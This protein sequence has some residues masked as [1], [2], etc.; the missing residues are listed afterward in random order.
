[1]IEADGRNVV[2]DVWAVL[3]KIKAFSDKA[4]PAGPP[5]GRH[6]RCPKVWPGLSPHQ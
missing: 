6:S 1:M 3:D 5:A 4:R 2:P